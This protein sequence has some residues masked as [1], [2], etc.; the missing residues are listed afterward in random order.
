MIS[1][2][3]QYEV[4]GRV[5]GPF[6]M[7]LQNYR[8][9]QRRRTRTPKENPFGPPIQCARKMKDLMSIYYYQGRWADGAVPV[10]W[11]TSGFPVEM[12]R[13]FGF[14]SVYPEN[15]G[16]LCAA[17]HMM[18]ELAAVAEEA[19]YSRDL[20][21]YARTDLGS[22]LSG[23]TPLGRVPK[24]DLVAACSNICQTVLYWFRSIADHL[25]VPFFVLDTPFVYGD[26]KQHH[27]EYVSDQLTELSEVAAEIS[28]RTVTEEELLAVNQRA[29]EGST[30]WAE[31][32]DTA[33]ARP[34]PWSSF[35]HFYH[36]APIVT[37]RGTEACNAYYREL[38][39]ELDDRVAKG[40]GGIKNERHRLLW[41]NIAIWPKMR[42]LSWLFASNDFCFVTATY[43]NAWR[44]SLPLWDPDD[45]VGSSARMLSN[46]ILNRDLKNRL[47]VIGGLIEDFDCDGVVLHSDRSCKPYSVGQYDL[48]DALTRELGVKVAVIEADHADPREYSD[49]QVETRLQAF[50]ES[51][52]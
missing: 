32:L 49:E 5:T 16:A 26:F 39:D 46:T 13:A 8:Q 35:D 14:Y 3:L 17:R 6:L 25:G 10:A 38:K 48:K 29:I 9:Q 44:E 30:L 31:C 43:T 20:C 18:P 42:D 19:G 1:R 12:L 2:R 7:A 28:G 24:P 22:V 21:A 23:N 50:M 52:G 41:D 47:R 51:F 36:L 27:L 37:L 15:H 34:S 33:R 45:L 40:I 4:A 11:V